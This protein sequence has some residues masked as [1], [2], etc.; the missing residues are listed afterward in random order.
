MFYIFLHTIL[1]SIE[2]PFAISL[3]KTNSDDV[4]TFSFRPSKT[5]SSQH[6]NK[7][8]LDR[9]HVITSPPFCDIVDDVIETI[10]GHTVVFGNKTQFK[11]TRGLFKT[12]GFNFN[13]KKKVLALNSLEKDV[14][15]L[16]NIAIK[17]QLTFRHTENYR[18][19]AINLIEKTEREVIPNVVTNFSISN[20]SHLNLNSFSNTAGVYYMRDSNNSIIYIGKAKQIKKRLKSHFS[21]QNKSSN[22]VYSDVNSIEVEYCGNDFIAQLIESSSIK[23]NQPKYN[24]QQKVTPKPYIINIGKTAKGIKKLSII[25]K[26]HQD[27]LPER[28]YNRNSVKDIL[29]TFC[30]EFNLCLKF[31]GVERVKG[32]CTNYVKGICYGICNN[33]EHM[34]SYNERVSEALKWFT[35]RNENVIYKLKGRSLQEDAFVYTFNGIYEG[36]GFIDK[37]APVSNHNDILDY[38]IPQ[39][40]NYDTARIIDSLNKK[41]KTDSVYR[42]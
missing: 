40:N 26:E 37:D 17:C 30:N 33:E 10:I 25:R 9:L 1:T 32:P 14:L 38:L 20:F 7:L 15:E 8:K 42:F 36:Y 41:I 31:T 29:R 5:I 34:R 28:Y 35:K 4:L 6:F 13:P 39:K 21:G 16:N 11:L 18:L 2:I 3:K 23:K 24:K 12:I 19:S 22:I 27:N